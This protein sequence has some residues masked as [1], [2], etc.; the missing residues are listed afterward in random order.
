MDVVLLER[1]EK[2]GQMGEVVSVKAGYARNFLLPRKKAL[3]ATKANLEV[4]QNQRAQLEAVNLERRQE[5]EAVAA[6]VQGLSVR[7]I[8]Q[9]GEAGTL[10]GSVGPRDLVAALADAGLSV[11]RQQVLLDHPIKQTGNHVVRVALHPEV[12]LPVAVIVATNEAAAESLEAADAGPEE[13]AGD[14]ADAAA[15]LDQV[16]PDEV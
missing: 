5:A 4:F 14:A 11:G 3:R 8:R 15:E 1:I 10:Y 12:I 16:A 6:R 2:L 9:A 13:T 7:M